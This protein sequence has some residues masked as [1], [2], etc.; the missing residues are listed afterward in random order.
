M[1]LGIELPLFTAAA[2]AATVLCLFLLNKVR[3]TSSKERVIRLRVNGRIVPLCMKVRK[4]Y[5]T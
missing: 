2:A 4:P 5:S 1:F 3:T